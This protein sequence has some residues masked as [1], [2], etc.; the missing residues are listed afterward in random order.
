MPVV[1]RNEQKLEIGAMPGAR[2]QS[3]ETATSTG[4]GIEQ[5]KQEK[6]GAVANFG[7]GVARMGAKLYE[8]IQAR[9]KES[10]DTTAIL[11]ARNKLAAAKNRILYDPDAG[12]LNK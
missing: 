10:A 1:R 3:A 8:D 12:A 9:E 5:A 4:A 2:L 6:A 7:A 11:E